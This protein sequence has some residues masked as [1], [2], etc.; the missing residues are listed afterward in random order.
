MDEIDISIRKANKH[1]K[2]MLAQDESSLSFWLKYFPTRNDA[3][4]FIRKC[5]RKLLTQRMMLI[6]EWYVNIA[7]NMPKIHD[8][9]PALQLIFLIALAEGVAKRRFT[10]KNCIIF[11]LF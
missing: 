3:S 1:M 9:R 10:K 8:S 4:N 7:D 11:P 5:L 2:Q 6:A